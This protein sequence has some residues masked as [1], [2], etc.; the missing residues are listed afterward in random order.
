MGNPYKIDYA[1]F[2]GSELS[3]L[4]SN[5]CKEA[6]LDCKDYSFAMGV[7][8]RNGLPWFTMTATPFPF[9]GNKTAQKVLQSTKIDPKRAQF[10]VEGFIKIA[11]LDRETEE[12]ASR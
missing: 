4:M 5:I 6:S 3:N 1:K 8:F 12:H 2:S 11:R 9:F 7:S 10:K